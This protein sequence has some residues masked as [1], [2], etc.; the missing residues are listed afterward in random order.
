MTAVLGILGAAALFGVMGF[1]ASR[2]GSRLGSSGSCHGDSCD[3]PSCTLHDECEGCG[4]EE[5]AAAWWPADG[6][7]YGDR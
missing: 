2:V 6:V 5:S 4:E 3:V 1:A 7:R